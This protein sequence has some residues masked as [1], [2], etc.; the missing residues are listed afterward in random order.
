MK[1]VAEEIEKLRTMKVPDLVERYTDLFGKPPGVKNREHLWKRC[2]WKVQENQFGGLSGKAKER[3]EELI[4][5][6]DLPLGEKTRT[7]S[8]VLKKNRRP[9][10]PAPGTTLTRIWKGQKIQVLVRDDGYE[11]DGDLFRSL[12][13]AARAVTGSKW[14]G[15]LFFG[16][17]NRKKAQ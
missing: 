12:T 3:L 5:E 11:W 17:T 7:V 6:I 16:L 2:A 10:D 9:D 4:T 8:G 13:A 14:N 1:S 15:R